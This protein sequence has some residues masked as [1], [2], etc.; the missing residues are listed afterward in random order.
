MTWPQS[1]RDGRGG[2][3]YLGSAYIPAAGEQGWGALRALDPRNGKM[4]WEYR[5]YSAPWS[6]TLSTA[7]GLVFAG[8]MEGYVIALDAVTGKELWHLQTGSSIYASPMAYAMDGKQYVVIPSGGALIA[9]A[10]PEDR[11]R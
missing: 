1:Y 4:K 8:D 10:L 6:G 9:L 5:Y 3:A 7:G 11:E 2:R